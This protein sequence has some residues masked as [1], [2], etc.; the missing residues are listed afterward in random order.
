MKMMRIIN[1]DDDDEDE[2]DHD[3]DDDDENGAD[4]DHAC[5]PQ[6]A[7]HGVTRLLQLAFPVAPAA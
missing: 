6:A 4:D 7:R 3:D 5:G 2:D 1:D